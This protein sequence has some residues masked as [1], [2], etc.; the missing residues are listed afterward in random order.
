MDKLKKT[1]PSIIKLLYQ[2][3]YDTKRILEFYKINYWMIAGTLLGAIRHKGVI[4]WDDDSDCGILSKDV[5]RFLSLR[6]VFKKIGYDIVDVWF[7]YKIIYSNRK[8]LKGEL[9]SFPNLDIFTFRLSSDKKKYEYSYA[10]ARNTWPKEFFTV[11]QLQNLKKYDFGSYKLYGPSNPEKY[12]TRAYGKDWYT[13]AYRQYDH[14]KDE[15]V[16]SVKVKLTDKDRVPATPFDEIVDRK[17]LNNICMLSQPSKALSSYIP[18]HPSKKRNHNFNCRMSTFVIHCK[19]HKERMEKFKK[20]SKNAGLSFMIEPCVNSSE[21]TPALLCKMRE[22]KIVSSKAQITP[23]ELAIC[24]SHYNVWRR[25]I[26]TGDDYGLIFEDDCTIDKTFI[27]K[28]NKYMNSLI[29]HDIAFDSFYIYNGNWGKEKVN[30][31][32]K[33]VIGDIYEETEAFNGGGACYVVSRE[34]CERIVSD[35]LPVEIPQD[36]FLGEI[37]GVHLTLKMKYN[38]KEDCVKSSLIHLDCLGEGGT[39]ASTQTYDAITVNKLSC[40]KCVN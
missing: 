16:E 31:D 9:Y 36:I 37:K 38:K 10:T 5:K 21:F 22:K 3:T 27:P 26:A 2:L 32:L 13:H 34:F 8:K 28:V 14:E 24:L 20:A 40:K 12:L 17:K 11:D 30:T 7:G 19:V 35:F 4:G 1:K 33:K 6:S 23:T 29:D 18:T 15:V 39:G 25:I